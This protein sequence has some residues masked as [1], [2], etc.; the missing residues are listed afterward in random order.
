MGRTEGPIHILFCFVDHFEPISAG[1]TLE[2]QRHRMR[3]WTEQYPLLAAQ[4]KDSYGRPPQHTWFY[5][6]ENYNSEYLDDLVRLCQQGLGEIELHFHHG[7]D[8]SESLRSKLSACISGFAAHGALQIRVPEPRTVYG[9]IHGNSALDNSRGD[10]AYCGINDELIILRDTGC[11]ADFSFPTAPCVSQPRKINA[12]YYAT[13]DP[14]RSKSYDLGVDVQVGGSSSGDL[15]IIS[16]PLALD[17]H[18]RKW[19]LVPR[20]DNA[21]IQQNYPATR[22]R[23]GNWVR[24]H[25]HVKG[26]P[27]WVVVKVS[28]HGAEERN[29]EAL[30][31]PSAEQM[32]LKA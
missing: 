12:I 24:Q 7:Y 16:G 9:F 8:T 26:R 22:N 23:I 27:E 25:V 17:W 21:E 28:C 3:K 15:M 32:P 5:P 11:Y 13:D 14:H 19:G 31:G 1:S 2:Q 20:I 4:H 29:G 30:L 6:G 10:Q 18:N